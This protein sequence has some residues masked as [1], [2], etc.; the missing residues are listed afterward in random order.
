MKLCVPALLRDTEICHLDSS[1]N[2]TRG[3]LLFAAAI[4]LPALAIWLRVTPAELP[5]VAGW[6]VGLSLATFAVYAWDKKKAKA[7]EWR[8]PEGT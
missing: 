4:V 2:I 5:W 1:R 8:T 7:L 3:L 6:I